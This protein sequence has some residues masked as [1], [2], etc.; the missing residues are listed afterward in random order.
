MPHVCW[1]ILLAQFSL[2]LIGA[3]TSAAELQTHGVTPVPQEMIG[4]SKDGR[5]FVGS[6]SGRAFKP[7][8]FNYDHDASDRLLEQYWKEEW[9]KVAADF[10]EMKALGAN[11]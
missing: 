10:E 6:S 1:L 4:L 7:W 8:G 9:K 11:T 2:A 3:E 5:G